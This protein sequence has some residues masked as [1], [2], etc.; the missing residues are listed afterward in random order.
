MDKLLRD[1]AKSEIQNK[2]MDI[3]RAYYIP[4]WHSQPYHQNQ[5]PA[6]WRYRTIKSDQHSHEHIWFT[7][8]LLATLHDLCVLYFQSHSMLCIGRINP[9]T[10]SIWIDQSCCSI[11][12][13]NLYSMQHMINIF[14][15][16]VK[17]ELPIG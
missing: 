7:C 10:C 11:H 9:I 14:H 6:E 3:L 5:N 2:A 4:N 16:R 13:I 17:N 8:K 12:F 1:S 15:L